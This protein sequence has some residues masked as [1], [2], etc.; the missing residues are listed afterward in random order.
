MATSL[1]TGMASPWQEDTPCPL[2][3]P[4]SLSHSFQGVPQLHHPGAL[5][6]V[7]LPIVILTH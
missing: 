3:L 6:G 5:P 7:I 2:A 1:L 4:L